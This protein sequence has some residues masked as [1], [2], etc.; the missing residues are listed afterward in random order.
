VQDSCCSAISQEKVANS[1]L[2]IQTSVHCSDL[3]LPDNVH[4][5]TTFEG[6]LAAEQSSPVLCISPKK[7]VSV[8]Q[9]AIVT[10]QQCSLD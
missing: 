8:T 6:T 4:P 10:L 1:S 7:S 2:Q 5:S 3:T 9:F